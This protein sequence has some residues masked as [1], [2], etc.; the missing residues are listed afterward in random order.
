MALRRKKGGATD[1][2]VKVFGLAARDRSTAV[3]QGSEEKDEDRRIS[4]GNVRFGS[5]PMG[6]RSI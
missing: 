4:D 3:L 2:L 5:T 6:V 1:L